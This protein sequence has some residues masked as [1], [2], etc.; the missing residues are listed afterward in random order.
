MNNDPIVDEIH[1]YRRAHAAKYDNNI[2]KIVEAYQ[3]LERISG[4]KFVDFGPKRLPVKH[5]S[6]EHDTY[7]QNEKAEH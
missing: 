5:A 2:D 4:R 7:N 3:E 6:E 1:R